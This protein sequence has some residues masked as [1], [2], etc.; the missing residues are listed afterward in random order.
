MEK[1]G[2][3]VTD[4]LQETLWRLEEVRHGF[5]TGSATGVQEALEWILSRQGLKGS[6]SGLFMPTSQDLAEGIRLPTGER[7]QTNAGARHI[8]GEEA[9]RTAIVWKLGSSSPVIEALKGLNQILDRGGR[10]GS[11]C[12]H[13]CTISFLRTLAVAKTGEADE[14]LDKGLNRIRKSRTSDGKWKG[15]PFY[16]TLLLLSE[17]SSSL[18][19][20][21]LR[22]AGKAAGSLLKRYRSDDRVSLFRRLVLKAAFD[23]I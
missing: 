3:L 12:C 8:L 10:S 13:P 22:H 2:I 19:K 4:S 21:E 15:F 6:Y 14:V 7:I 11:Y 17:T 16:Y 9:L 23:A 20:E 5:R 18:A 1:E